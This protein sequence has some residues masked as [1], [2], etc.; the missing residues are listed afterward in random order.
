MNNEDK[1]NNIIWLIMLMLLC[2]DDGTDDFTKLII[3]E[4]KKI[5]KEKPFSPKKL[6]KTILKIMEEN[7]IKT[8]SL[9]PKTLKMVK[10]YIEQEKIKE[11]E[12]H[13]GFQGIHIEIG[14]RGERD[15]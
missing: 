12:K 6:E 15:E 8:I 3:N 10:E 14:E 1:S 2:D 11:I 7:K 5:I 13:K 9:S 4:S